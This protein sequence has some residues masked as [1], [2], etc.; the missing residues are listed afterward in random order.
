ME[1]AAYVFKPFVFLELHKIQTKNLVCK[2]TSIYLL[3]FKLSLSISGTQNS[4]TE[5]HFLNSVS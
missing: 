1:L 4:L 5:K 2:N 3:I